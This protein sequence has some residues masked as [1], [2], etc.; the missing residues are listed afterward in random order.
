M[1][2]YLR[3]SWNRDEPRDTEKHK[4][5]KNFKNLGSIYFFSPFRDYNIS[6]FFWGFFEEAIIFLKISKNEL[7]KYAR[8]L[9]TTHPYVN[10]IEPTE[11][12]NGDPRN[13][14]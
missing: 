9:V 3:L 2:G 13:A 8:F 14:S 11:G 6:P 4:N 1:I 12:I 5:T 10:P 7:R